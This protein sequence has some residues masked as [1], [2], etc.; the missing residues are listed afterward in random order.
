MNDRQR[1][2][3]RNGRS[4]RYGHPDRCSAVQQIIDDFAVLGPQRVLALIID[5]VRLKNRVTPRRLVSGV[6]TGAMTAVLFRRPL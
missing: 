6:M 2:W 5:N 4:D 3:R 1:A